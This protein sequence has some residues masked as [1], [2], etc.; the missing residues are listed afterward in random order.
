M[1]ESRVTNLD[2]AGALEK[3]VRL[4]S[5]L[6]LCNGVVEMLSAKR[7]RSLRPV[8]DKGSCLCAKQGGDNDFDDDNARGPPRANL[9]FDEGVSR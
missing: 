2:R 3:R 6:L 4:S 7:L 8:I 5:V 9:N 1:P